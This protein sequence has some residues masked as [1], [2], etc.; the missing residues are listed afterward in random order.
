MSVRFQLSLYVI[1]KNLI[2]INYQEYQM[3]KEQYLRQNYKKS[4]LL[5]IET[6]HKF[7]IIRRGNYYE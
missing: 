4:V 5:K 1:F 7:L 2:N 3:I 6:I